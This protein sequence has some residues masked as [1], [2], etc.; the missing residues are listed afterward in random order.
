MERVKYGFM[1]GGVDNTVAT[2]EEGS[3]IL[4]GTLNTISGTNG[5]RRQGIVGGTGNTITAAVQ[6]QQDNVILGGSGN[7]LGS[8]ANSSR[9]VI[10]G[11]TN[12]VVNNTDCLIGGV[13]ITCT[14]KENFM[15][16]TGGPN[17]G[18]V[19]N[20][21]FVVKATG[22]STFWSNN[23]G[24]VGVSLAAGGN[25]WAP[26]CDVNVKENLLPCAPTLGK[27]ELLPIYTY[28]YIGN[29]PEQVCIGPTA[30]GWHAQFG[31]A[32][33]PTYGVDEETGETI[34]V[35]TH[36]AKDPLSIEI[37][38]VVG[39]LLC[40]VKELTARVKVLEGGGS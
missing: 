11:G 36:P 21:Q 26:V 18:S 23:P 19:A 4:G 20:D 38:D 28:N 33:V 5:H 22:G 10:L 31:T 2:T 32:D 37:M 30:Q 1:G 35:G 24:T 25:S 8:S 39:V 13:N 15:W 29:P 7:T 16:S 9:S 12:C 17:L 14:H 27:L 6:N 40:A 3:F 34:V